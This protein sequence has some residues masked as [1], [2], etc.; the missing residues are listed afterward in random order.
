MLCSAVGRLVE[1]A[2]K[3][4]EF[5]L[6]IQRIIQAGLIKH[7]KQYFW[8]IDDEC[9]LSG[10]TEMNVVKVYIN[11]MQGAFYVIMLGNYIYFLR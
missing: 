2:G 10:G 8:P 6:R 4:K 11:D 5:F 9:I 3:N 7:W 1:Y